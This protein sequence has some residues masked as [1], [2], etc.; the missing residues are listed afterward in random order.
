MDAGSPSMLDRNG[1]S[2]PEGWTESPTACKVCGSSMLVAPSAVFPDRGVLLGRTP[3]LGVFEH[4]HHMLRQETSFASVDVQV[5]RKEKTLAFAWSLH[6]WAEWSGNSISSR[7][8]AW[9]VNHLQVQMWGLVDFILDDV[10]PV[11]GVKLA[12]E[13]EALPVPTLSESAP[14]LGQ[15]DLPPGHPDWG[16]CFLMEVQSQSLPDTA[17]T[18]LT[19]RVKWETILGLPTCGN[20]WCHTSHGQDSKWGTLALCGGAD[21]H[22]LCCGVQELGDLGAWDSWCQL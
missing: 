21:C 3:C 20:R 22:V 8:M 1:C 14:R 11:P 12:L 18:V 15:G 13:L 16:D 7:C 5:L 4:H 17:A 6:M 2:A 9:S 19:W 10:P